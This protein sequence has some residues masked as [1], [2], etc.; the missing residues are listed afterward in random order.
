MPQ[1]NGRR[2]EFVRLVAAR[3]VQAACAA[4]T[5]IPVIV[6]PSS[7]VFC[8]GF[9]GGLAYS[10]PSGAGSQLAAPTYA[11]NARRGPRVRRQA[12]WSITFALEG[13]VAI[14]A[15]AEKET[16]PL[17]HLCSVGAHEEGVPQRLNRLVEILGETFGVT[18]VLVE[19]E[20]AERFALEGETLSAEVLAQASRV[21]RRQVSP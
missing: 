20:I 16:P 13:D 9:L 15:L 7:S 4:S 17:Y 18:A 1:E 19:E 12:R 10:F 8:A 14:L 21:P 3:C 6:S 5:V 11:G 2:G